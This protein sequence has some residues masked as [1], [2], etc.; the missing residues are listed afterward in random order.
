MPEGRA[1]DLARLQE[2]VL[3]LALAP[4]DAAFREDPA[5]FARIL[6]LGTAHQQSLAARRDRWLLY[7]NLVRTA[8]E[9]P[10]G[11][12]LPVTQ[13]LLEAAD[14][15]EDAVAAFLASR[16]LQSPYYREIP[17][18]FVAWL[19][20]SRWGQDRWPFL[21][22]LA[23][24]EVLELEVV[25]H[26]DGPPPPGLGPE[27]ALDRVAVL[28]PSVRNLA[29]GYAVQHATVEA[30][31]PP[32][33]CAWLLCYRDAEGA[34][35][36]L[37][38]TPHVS[39]LLARSQEGQALGPALAELGVTAEEAFPLLRDFRDRGILLGFRKA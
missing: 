39:A 15:W 14:A 26:P 29:Y 34:F 36:V 28:D 3:D 10:L 20:D 35:R 4:D 33:A 32:R 23:H 9:D 13:A 17:A 1:S 11:D 22:P 25:R 19:A 8:L 6:G 5:A 18:A 12:A 7:R 30:P 24:F 37:E 38:L 16:T 21:L 2:L 31:E 27:P